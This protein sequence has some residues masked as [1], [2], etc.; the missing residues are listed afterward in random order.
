MIDLPVFRIARDDDLLDW[1]GARVYELHRECDVQRAFADLKPMLDDV[2]RVLGYRDGEATVSQVGSLALHLALGCSF[3]FCDRT[4]AARLV[5]ASF[6]VLSQLLSRIALPLPREP[7]EPKPLSAPQAD[8]LTDL[9]R[10]GTWHGVDP[11]QRVSLACHLYR[12]VAQRLEPADALA[13][14]GWV[15]TAKCPTWTRRFLGLA[16]H[17]AQVVQQL[18]LAEVQSELEQVAK[19][20]LRLSGR[21]VPERLGRE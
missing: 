20:L 14:I 8:A 10:I 4:S 5:A 16:D 1:S 12:H 18:I 7:T 15:L 2:L 21:V 6:H 9:L 17:S 13:W 11:Q 19:E 3:S